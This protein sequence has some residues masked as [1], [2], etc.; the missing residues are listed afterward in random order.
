MKIKHQKKKTAKQLGNELE[1]EI[2]K[3]ARK[4]K[5]KVISNIYIG[6]KTYDRKQKYVEVDIVLINQKGIVVIEAK[7][8]RGSI[9]G[10]IKDIYWKVNYAD[11]GKNYNLYNPVKQ[12]ESHTNKVKTFLN[13]K[14]DIVNSLIIFSDSSNL[15]ISNDNEVECNIKLLNELPEYLNSL[16]ENK[17]VLTEKKVHSYVEKLKKRTKVSSLIK[18]RHKKQVKQYKNNTFKS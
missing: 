15:N 8:Y 18:K 16:K 7:N 14:S 17:D 5:Y 1:K 13:V 4:H 6:Y 10:D 11:S 9:S 12:N 3:I 2:K